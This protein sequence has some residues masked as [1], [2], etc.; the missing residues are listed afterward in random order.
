[1]INLSEGDAYKVTYRSRKEPKGAKHN[2]RSWIKDD[3]SKIFDKLDKKSQEYGY[4]DYI[5]YYKDVHMKKREV[6]IPEIEDLYVDLD[7]DL[8]RLSN[9]EKKAQDNHVEI[10][11]PMTGGVLYKGTTGNCIYRFE[12]NERKFYEKHFSR[13]IY[14][15]N[16]RAIE[17]R[18]YDRI[19]SMDESIDAYLLDKKTCPT[20]DIFQI[21]EKN[22]HVSQKQLLA[23]YEEFNKRREAFHKEKGIKMFRF[24]M[25][26]HL[27]ET[28]PHIQE[29][30][31]FIAVDKNGVET[32]NVSACLR[33]AGYELPRPGKKRS[34]YN[35]YRIPYSK[36]IRAIWIE[37]CR[38][39]GLEIDDVPRPKTKH[40][41]T[42]EYRLQAVEQELRT[43][44]KELDERTDTLDSLKNALNA[45]KSDLDVRHEEYVQNDAKLRKREN[46]V[47]I[48]EKQL[49]ER[50]REL[51]EREQNID[52]KVKKREDAAK[53]RCKANAD[54]KKEEYKTYINNKKQELRAEYDRLN[55]DI[56]KQHA[57]LKAQ[58]D[59]IAK[60]YAKL[61]TQQD[62]IQER[63]RR[64]KKMAE[65]YAGLIETGRKARAEKLKNNVH[66]FSLDALV[67]NNGYG[68]GS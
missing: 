43:Q 34:P 21:G 18:N 46:T 7:D 11:D 45:L 44:K 35:H 5:A 31:V 9:L 51:D 4:K 61:K 64:V 26:M 58:Q 8:A 57:E 3:I 25:A 32:A 55:N 59:D 60:Q 29:R 16:K 68:L 27:D 62:D 39:F 54:E 24:S 53:A 56:A 67:K 36:D 28:T 12:E 6:Q 33:D 40:V 38:D 14:E 13:C 41:E 65:E 37:T 23:C 17:H 20:E 10:I 30:S 15:R 2:D 48:R 1:M 50:E 66:D 49:D 42:R 47:D 63:E 19:K 52:I 22:H